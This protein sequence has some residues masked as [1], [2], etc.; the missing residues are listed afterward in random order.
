MKNS[1]RAVLLGVALCAIAFLAA[2]THVTPKSDQ[3][4]VYASS[5]TVGTALI[6][7]DTY[8]ALN[9]CSK[10]G[11]TLPCADDAIRLQVQ[12]AKLKLVSAWKAAD[13]IVNSPGYDQ[14]SYSKAM[15]IVQG[16]LDFLISITP[17]SS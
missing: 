1:F 3:Q 9:S 2:C 17:P 13:A 4:A 16:A 6:A 8:Q 10:V 7:A 11:H 14:G 5:A 12:D 15:A